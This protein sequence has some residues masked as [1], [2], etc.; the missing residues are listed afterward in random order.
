MQK[1]SNEFSM[2]DALRLAQSEVGQQLY[3]MLKSQNAEV[4]SK[5]MEQAASG[6]YTQVKETL[7]TLLSSPQIRSMLEKMGRNDHE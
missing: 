4:V 2:Q 3:A 6:D 7:S 5:A 1:N